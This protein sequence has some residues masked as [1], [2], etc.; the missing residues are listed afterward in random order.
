MRVLISNAHYN[1]NKNI[2]NSIFALPPFGMSIEMQPRVG[3]F[4]PALPEHALNN[5]ASPRPVQI[6]KW[7]IAYVA[8]V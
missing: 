2:W 1:G 3:L 5:M 8:Y 6:K 7:K 4:K